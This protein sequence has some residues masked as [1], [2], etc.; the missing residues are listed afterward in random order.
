MLH[1]KR[2]RKLLRARLAWFFA[3]G[4]N[5]SGRLGGQ[6]WYPTENRRMLAQ[7]FFQNR[8]KFGAR[9][10]TKIVGMNALF[11]DGA[12]VFLRLAILGDQQDVSAERVCDRE[13]Q[14]H[15]GVQ[16]REIHY[17]VRRA[18]DLVPNRAQNVGLEHLIAA[19]VL[20]CAAARF[21]DDSARRA[22]PMGPER[23]HMKASLC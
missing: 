22:R 1:L 4:R 17:D 16:S 23:S 14:G 3:R 2:I 18:A 19:D 12:E 6:I 7:K 15:V 20:N 13:F 10:S 9:I 8:R 5:G 11:G 21:G